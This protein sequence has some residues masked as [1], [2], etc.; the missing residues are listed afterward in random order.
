MASE[1]VFNFTWLQFAAGDGCQTLGLLTAIML[2]M[3]TF[4][5]TLIFI[6]SVG[7]MA[8]DDFTRFFTFLCSPRD[9]RV[10]HRRIVCC[11][12]FI[13]WESS[14]HIVS[15][16]RLL[17]SQPERAGGAKKGIHHH[18]HWYVAFLLGMGW[19]KCAER[20]VCCSMTTVLAAWNSPLWP[21]SCANHWHR[22]G[23]STAIG[24]LIFA[25]RWKIP[26][27]CLCTFGYQTR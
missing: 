13:C 15:T 12:L 5:G 1:K 8:H 17:V 19:L 3:V 14:P 2:V 23:V 27:K 4:V 25:V 9:A 21:A 24:L 16:H 11:C 10:V 22:H 7:Y 6:Y 20:N 26:A 18:A